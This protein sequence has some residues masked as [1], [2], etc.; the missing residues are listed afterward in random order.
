[1]TTLLPGSTK[2]GWLTLR[3]GDDFVIDHR[4]NNSLGF[5]PKAMAIVDDEE[6]SDRGG[7][8]AGTP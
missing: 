2:I 1:M 3:D 8:C 6:V 7:A 5:T 4:V